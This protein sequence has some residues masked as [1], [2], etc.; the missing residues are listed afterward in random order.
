[1]FSVDIYS[2]R[3]TD[4]L[5]VSAELIAKMIGDKA[6]YCPS[7]AATADAIYTEARENDVVI[8][9]GA[10]DIYKVFECLGDRLRSDGGKK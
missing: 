8:V 1:M 4:T 3:E 6:T 10:G 9:M 2:A 5:G 7:F